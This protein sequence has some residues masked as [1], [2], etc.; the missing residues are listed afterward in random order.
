MFLWL[1]KFVSATISE[2]DWDSDVKA[3]DV[4]MSGTISSGVS[5]AWKAYVVSSVFCFFFAGDIE[6]ILKSFQ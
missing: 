1:K 3:V 4:Q 5:K 2:F 6:G